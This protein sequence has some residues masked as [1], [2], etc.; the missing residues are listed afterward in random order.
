[1]NILV[2][3]GTGF[4]GRALCGEL[5]AAGHAVTV[6]SR[7][8]QRVTAL[9]GRRV[10]AMASLA[11]WTPDMAFDAVINLAGE[12]IVDKAWTASRKQALRDSRI[13]ITGQLL[14]AMSRAARPPQVFLS[15]SAIGYYG[16][17]G[18]RVLDE[19]SPPAD[20]FSAQLCFDWEVAAEPAVALGVRTCLLRTGLV[21]DA[22]GGL[23]GK[24]LPV[25]RFGLGGRLGSG[26]Q[27]M[28]WITLADYNAI[29]LQLLADTQARGAFNLTAP[30]PVTNAEFTR[31][32]ARALHRPAFFHAPAPALKLAL[33]ERAPMLLGGQ[34]VVPAQALARGYAFADPTLD[35]ALARLLSR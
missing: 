29:V 32:L 9:C 10:Q 31:S 24:L 26:K 14:Q 12:P 19:S 6:L 8:P 16:N 23:L 30:T 2:T 22:S 1:M 21:L 35:V 34:R 3:G 15:G 33:G 27:W 20:D 13:G 18:D 4:I 11:Q 25:F 28:S 5:T 7:Q 17:T